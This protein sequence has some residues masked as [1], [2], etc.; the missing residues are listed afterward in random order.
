MALALGVGIATG[1]ARRFT[2]GDPT[3]HYVDTLAGDTVARTSTAKN[4]AQQGEVL[5]DEATVGA[6]GKS[7][8]IKEWR[9]DA[10]SGE[11][12]A[13]LRKSDHPSGTL[14]QSD[15]GSY[16]RPEFRLDWQFDPQRSMPTDLRPPTAEALQGWV[17]RAVYERERLGQDTFLTEFRPCVAVFVSF[18]GIDYDSAEAQTLLDEFVR[19]AQGIA[20]AYDGMLM[21]LTIGD[22][23]SYAY[24]NFGALTAHEDD[25]RR[26]VKMALD[27]RNTSSLSLQIGITQGVMR[28]GAYGGE[29]RR[30]YGALGSD[31]NLAARLMTTANAGEILLSGDVHRVVMGQFTFEPRPPLLIEGIAE[32]LLVLAVTG[33]RQ[34][35]PIRLQEPTY[36]LPM[37]GRTDELQ[38]INDKL[39]LAL[40][41]RGQ[42]IG[43][44]AEAGMGKSR[45]VA[46]AIRLARKKGFVGYG[47]ACQSD[48][49]NTPYQAWKSIWAAFFGV[50]PS[51]PLQEQIRSLE[52]EI[53]NR[54]PERSRALPL[55]GIL[56]NLEIPDN[57]FTKGLE[58]RYRQSALRALLEDCLRA[59]AKDEQ[60]LIVI[61][62][63]HWI[64]GLSQDLLVELARALSDSRACFV[65]A[66]RPPQLARLEA[67]RLE[68]V[69]DFTRIE[70][71]EL[72]ASE[73]ERAIRAKWAVV[74]RGAAQCRLGW[75]TS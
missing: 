14:W 3:I 20:A 64:D 45:L 9:T 63:L 15:W 1:A 43:I 74:S 11:R 27:L 13:V 53:A 69:P 56:L 58:P 62:D 71:H 66:Y 40:N 34:S 18:S 47:G 6:L 17:H 38:L 52:N 59:A 37:V 36:A 70:L 49:V 55:L 35:H 41:A 30:V 51:M 31:V 72:N 22:K 48:A 46:E 33:A 32:P 23:G 65:L 57:E 39:D 50:D 19:Q 10:E 7:L 26:A 12:F 54:A 21:D 28:V 75:S 16:W 5:S 42:V 68:A 67:P 73:A 2:V 8:T 29:T 25:A 44:V 24:V 4:Q 60:L 61:E